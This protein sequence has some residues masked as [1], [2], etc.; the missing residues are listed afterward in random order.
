MIRPKNETEDSLL[1]ITKICETL[2]KQTHRKAEGTLEFEKNKSRE[3]F[4]FKPPIQVKRIWMIGLVD[5]EVYNSIFNITEENNKFELYIFP[6]EKSGGISN[7]KIRD[8]IERDLDISDITAA[9]LQDDI[10][11]PI[12]IDE[13]REQVLK[14]ME[15]DGYMDILSGYPRSV[16]Q[17]F[18]SYLRTEID[19]IEDDIRLFLD[20]YNSSFVTY[21]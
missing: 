13:C 19:L 8:E 10:I 5:L 21:E 1:S 12:I 6:D 7:E 15:D 11:G 2:I 16:F 18:E 9:D 4:H 14:R 3:I 17:N 20:K